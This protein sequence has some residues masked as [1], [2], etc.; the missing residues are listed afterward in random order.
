MLS[1]CVPKFVL[2]PTAF[3]WQL[4]SMMPCSHPAW[5][6][7]ATQHSV[8][9][10]TRMVSSSR[11][12]WFCAAPAW[13][14]VCRC[15]RSMATSTRSGK[16]NRAAS[17]PNYRISNPAGLQLAQ[18]TSPSLQPTVLFIIGGYIT[19]NYR[20]STLAWLQLALSTS[21]LLRPTP[22]FTIGGLST[23]NSPPQPPATWH[24]GA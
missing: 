5:C 11:P 16:Q 12:S 10:Q 2:Q 19:P 17:T 6:Y 14:H 4:P 8:M 7:A 9:Q 13:R 22:L 18:S 21:P 1:T 20:I 24:C 15:S 23:P 3:N